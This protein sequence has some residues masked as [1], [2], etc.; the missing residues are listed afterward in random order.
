[1]HHRRGA[2]GLGGAETTTTAC[3]VVVSLCF[4]LACA[5]F[6]F[7]LIEGCRV[8]MEGMI[9]T[10]S[11]QFAFEFSL[12]GFMGFIISPLA[13]FHHEMA[14]FSNIIYQQTVSISI[15]LNAEELPAS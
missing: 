9:S 4:P 7:N 3:T 6:N 10:W 1:M 14:R 5:A 15:G 13:V 12:K 2:P 11:P 8:E